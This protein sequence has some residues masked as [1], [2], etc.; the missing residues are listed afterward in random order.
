MPGPGGPRPGGPRPGG[1]RPGGP[2]PGG[3]HPRHRGPG[4]GGCFFCF[5]FMIG[6]GA[7]LISGIVCAIV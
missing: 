6:I 1:P 3:P 5:L 4:C 2:R 7:L